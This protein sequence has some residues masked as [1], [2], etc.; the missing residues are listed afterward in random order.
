M[1]LVVYLF[2]YLVRGPFNVSCVRIEIVLAYEKL[3]FENS[4]IKVIN[5]IASRSF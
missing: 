2:N 3:K 1:A 5:A 4:L